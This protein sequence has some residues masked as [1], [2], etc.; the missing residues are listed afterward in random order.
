MC[1]RLYPGP[2]DVGLRVTDA[3][4]TYEIQKDERNK[5]KIG[6]FVRLMLLLT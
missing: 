1:L 6:F 2:L 5:I 4:K 3:V